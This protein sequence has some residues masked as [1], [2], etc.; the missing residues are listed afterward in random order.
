ML[1][2]FFCL[3]IYSTPKEKKI[4]H[5][6]L[7]KRDNFILFSPFK[8]SKIKFISQNTVCEWAMLHL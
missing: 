1:P 5:M 7:F 2:K 4:P 3:N 8:V 6:I